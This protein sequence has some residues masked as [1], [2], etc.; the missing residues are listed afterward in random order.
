[1]QLRLIHQLHLLEEGVQPH[2]YIN[3]ADLTDLEKKTLKEAFEVIR[4]IQSSLNQQFR[5]REI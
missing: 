1:M 2:N 5:L 4:K 3:P